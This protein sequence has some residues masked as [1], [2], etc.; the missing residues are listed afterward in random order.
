MALVNKFN[1]TSKVA[2]KLAAGH[3][4]NVGWY[5]GEWREYRDVPSRLELSKVGF[6]W[7]SDDGTIHLKTHNRST[8]TCA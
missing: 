6:A 7:V 1:M 5:K 3:G 4:V 8:T 2:E